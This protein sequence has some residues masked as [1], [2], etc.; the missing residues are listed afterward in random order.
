[1]L[2]MNLRKK[3]RGKRTQTTTYDQRLRWRRQSFPDES[4][5]GTKPGS[6][7]HSRVVFQMCPSI[8][9]RP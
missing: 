9:T 6:A 5:C 2:S 3:A 8:E 1:M 4:R 7:L